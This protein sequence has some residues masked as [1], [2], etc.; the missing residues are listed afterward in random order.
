MRHQFLS[1]LRAIH[2]IN[3][4][5]GQKLSKTARVISNGGRNP[6]RITPN[7]GQKKGSCESYTNLSA[8]YM[9]CTA[10]KHPNYQTNKQHMQ[11]YIISYL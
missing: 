5:K 11:Q 4:F 9:P 2:S 7:T 1:Y 6:T 8:I 10:L 3:K